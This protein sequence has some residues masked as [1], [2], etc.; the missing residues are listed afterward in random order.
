MTTNRDPD[1]LLRAW[2]DLMPDEAPDRAIAAALQAAEH[3]P[4]VR[5]LVPT[6]RWSSTN[7]LSVAIAAAAVVVV[8]GGGVLLVGPSMLV[9]PS[10]APSNQPSSTALPA[11]SQAAAVISEDLQGDWLGAERVVTGL[12]ADAGTHLRIAADTVEITQSNNQD[13]PLLRAGA[14]S[15]SGELHLFGQ[16]T[17]PQQC[18]ASSSGT[19]RV[20]L[21]PSGQ[22]LTL[23]LVSDDCE[24]RGPAIAG[25]WWRSD[26]PGKSCLGLI[27]PG[28]Y[29]TQS[30]L[31][32]MSRPGEWRPE[33][34]GMAFS[35]T[36]PW[37]QVADSPTN[38][39]LVSPEQFAKW[40][41]DGGPED[42][43]DIFVFTQP[44]AIL[45]G[46]ACHD[47]AEVDPSVGRS[48][49]E[50]MAF[51]SSQPGIEASEISD[52]TIDDY[53]GKMVDLQ[54]ATPYTGGCPGSPRGQN[55][56]VSSL[57]RDF[58]DYQVGLHGTQQTR[59]ILVAIGG[60]DV[61]GIAIEASGPDW[62]AELDAAL[63]I[64]HSFTFK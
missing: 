7:R 27:D 59:L 2:L 47:P 5:S 49:E 15:A 63:P 42:R 31:P 35:T 56:L 62:E 8:L 36:V 1:R 14:R 40:T 58:A 38:T 37:A 54:L 30:F 24:A 25:T 20:E 55:L 9:G 12:A 57:G 60:S 46:P 45:D 43:S 6:F 10:A 11:G 3:A 52:A 29:G 23:A 33:F 26:C 39:I 41:T 53:D 48:V 4:Q 17:T 44:A 28:T 51:V 19:Y 21:S 13:T 32:R 50:L 22:T 34:G 61:V 16:G 64:V 18:P